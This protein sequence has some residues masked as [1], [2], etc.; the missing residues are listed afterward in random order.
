MPPPFVAGPAGAA[1]A[2]FLA[3]A[4]GVFLSRPAVETSAARRPVP[5]AA[6]LAPPPEDVYFLPV[7]RFEPL[8]MPLSFCFPARHSRP[9]QRRDPAPDA[10]APD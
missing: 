5:R 3:A 4:G 9:G 1:L 6:L 8:V 7:R 2:V 10:G